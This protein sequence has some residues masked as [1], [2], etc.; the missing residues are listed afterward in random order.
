MFVKLT[1]LEGGQRL[2]TDSV[3]GVTQ[4]LPTVGQQFFMAAESLTK[5][6][7][8]SPMGHRQV[9]TSVV[10]ELVYADDVWTFTT[11]SGSK[12]MLER[13]IEEES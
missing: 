1:R 8:G 13:I 6:D 12:Y 11:H 10:T 9:N 4:T 5:A 3:E 7:D 2:R